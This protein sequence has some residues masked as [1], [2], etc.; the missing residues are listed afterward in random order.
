LLKV[1]V[2]PRRA[3]NG[4]QRERVRLALAAFGFGEEAPRAIHPTEEPVG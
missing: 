4:R 3:G 1:S 2:Y